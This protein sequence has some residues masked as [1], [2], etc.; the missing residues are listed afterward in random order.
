[1]AVGSVTSAVGGPSGRCGACGAIATGGAGDRSGS[2]LHARATARTAKGASLRE[3][4]F[5]VLAGG[6]R[7]AI[8]AGQALSALVLV[9]GL[10]AVCRVL[11]H[12][13]VNAQVGGL[14]L[15]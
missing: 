12:L 5:G 3:A 10:H 9:R 6:L 7:K 14:E 11:A 13:L 8:D 1:M 15:S 4:P 2:S